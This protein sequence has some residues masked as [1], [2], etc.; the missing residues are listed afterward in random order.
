MTTSMFVADE[1]KVLGPTSTMPLVVIT[2]RP[3]TGKTTVA[4]KLKAYLEAQGCTVNVVNEEALGVP[5]RTG[6]RS[7]CCGLLVFLCWC[8][9]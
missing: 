1:Q 6:Y 5:H 9:W 2:G 8:R 7:A 3:C 4:K